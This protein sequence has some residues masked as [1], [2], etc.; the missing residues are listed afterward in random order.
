MAR[1]HRRPV[2]GWGRRHAHRQHPAVLLDFAWEGD[3]SLH[4]YVDDGQ[5]AS[6]DFRFFQEDGQWVFFEE[7][8]LP[9]GL[10]QSYE[11]VP[12]EVNGNRVR[13]VTP[14]APDYLAV[15]IEVD[16]ERFQMDVSVLGRSH[17]AFDL[18]RL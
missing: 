14:M 15:E 9:G 16:D 11:L 17:A 8:T 13:W 3:G 2:A 4:T 1:R 5:G 7:G 10:T 6:F 12:V 18:S